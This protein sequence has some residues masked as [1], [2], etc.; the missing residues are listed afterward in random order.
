ELTVARIGEMLVGTV[1]AEPTTTVGARIRAAMGR[2]AGVP[3]DR[4]VLLGVTNGYV[5]YVTTPEEYRHQFYEGGATQFGPRSA[6]FF[7]Q[8]LSRLA[9]TLRP[10]GKGE[11]PGF[12]APLF[13]Y[14]GAPLASFPGAGSGPAPGD[15]RRRFRCAGFSG[16]TLAA[17]WNDLHPGRL[18]PADAPVL[19][20]KRAGGDGAWQTVAWDDD[21]ELEVR[22]LR[23]LGSDGYEW[24]ARWLPRV[25]AA[26]T[27]RVVLLERNGISEL[28]SGDLVP[29]G[30]GPGCR[31]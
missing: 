21:H 7:Q 25:P 31:R 9:A 13:A 18:V 27:Y 1:P 12:V 26:G 15:L 30:S 6:L 5:Q 10:G 24:E 29:A 3:V 23:A 16:D 22:A 28:S 11:P 8:A 17:R 20:I 19:A 14:I 4:V 2:H